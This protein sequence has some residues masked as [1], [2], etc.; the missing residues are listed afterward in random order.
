MD[1]IISVTIMIYADMKQDLQFLHFVLMILQLTILAKTMPI[2]SLIHS[3]KV[4]TKK[5]NTT[6]AAPYTGIM[7]KDMWM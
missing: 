1:I 3:K 5:E 6:A 4:W 2:I 7:M